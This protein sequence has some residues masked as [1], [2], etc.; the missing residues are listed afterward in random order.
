MLGADDCP[1]QGD[2]FVQDVAAAVKKAGG[3]WKNPC[4]G[5]KEGK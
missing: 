1:L 5:I 3:L 2:R 4:K